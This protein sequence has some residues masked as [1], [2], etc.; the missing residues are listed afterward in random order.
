MDTGWN[1]FNIYLAG[2]LAALTVTG[3]SSMASKKED[4]VLRVHAEAKSNTTF[5]RKITV[6]RHAPLEMTIDQSV[7]LNE[8]MVTKA[9]VVNTLGGF[10]LAIQFDKRGQWLLDEHSSLNLGKHLAIFAMIGEKKKS[11]SR[12][13]AAPIIS[14]RITDGM[15]I[16]TPDLTREEA[17]QVAAG[18]NRLAASDSSKSEELK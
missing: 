18:L 8:T 6:Y 9:K 17:E 3:C 11:E 12:W 1:R 16:F 2:L 7:F 14:N 5:T 13:I 4:A 10:A 15:L